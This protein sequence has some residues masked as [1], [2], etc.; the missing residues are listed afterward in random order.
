MSDMEHVYIEI[1]QRI[2]SGA[3]FSLPRE[4]LERFVAALSMSNA[5]THFSASGFPGT[6]ETVRMALSIR[7]SEDV[8]RQAKRESRIALVVSSFALGAGV[9]GAIAALWPIIFPSPTQ[10]YA[11]PSKPVHVVSPE[12]PA[13]PMSQAEKIAPPTS[14]P[15]KSFTS[16][17]SPAKEGKK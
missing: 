5:F 16:S 13:P 3:V 15:S 9:V 6:C 4:K 17:Q 12:Q 7:I 2:N 11:L 8:N 1:Q 14:S 10:V